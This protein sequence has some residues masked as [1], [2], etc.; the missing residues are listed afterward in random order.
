MV[1]LTELEKDVL[2]NGIYESC[3]NEVTAENL[4]RWGEEY[5]ENRNIISVWTDCIIDDCEKTQLKQ[6]S[7]VISSLSKKG[8][9]ICG[10]ET[11]E[12]T[13]EGWEEI[14]KCL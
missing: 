9:V 12:V 8:L 5:G 3:Y 13:K 1:T 11:V 4:K 14:L 6:L 10:D 2:K 7:G